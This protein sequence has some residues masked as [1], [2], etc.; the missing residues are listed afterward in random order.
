[1]F[2]HEP[3]G[4]TGE[5]FNGSTY[6]CVWIQLFWMA[7]HVFWIWAVSDATKSAGHFA[8]N[9]FQHAWNT[10]H[11]RWSVSSVLGAI[12]LNLEKGH[13]SM[14]E[15]IFEGK[16]ALTKAPIKTNRT[17]HPHLSKCMVCASLDA[18]LTSLRPSCPGVGQA[19]VGSSGARPA[20]PFVWRLL[21]CNLC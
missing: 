18:N 11:I 20:T 12:F 6:S 7:G 16:N 13:S 15:D 1:M 17:M 5:M 4:W 9:C 2:R 8:T 19:P 10:A 14:T 3:E 21:S